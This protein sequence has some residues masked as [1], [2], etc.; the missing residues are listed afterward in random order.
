M[1]S[2]L[3]LWPDALLA[4]DPSSTGSGFAQRLWC[5]RRR[6]GRHLSLQPLQLRPRCPPTISSIGCSSR[7]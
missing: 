7:L 5:R 3:N 6:R 4:V 2:L 1:S